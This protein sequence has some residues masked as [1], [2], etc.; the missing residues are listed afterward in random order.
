M[1]ILKGTENICPFP[2][3]W[4]ISAERKHHVFLWNVEFWSSRA[5]QGDADYSL[6][7][8]LIVM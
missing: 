5:E 8:I 7:Q 2:R 4:K 3:L 6:Q 1:S